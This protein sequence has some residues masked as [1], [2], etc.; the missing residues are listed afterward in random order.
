M[1]LLQQILSV[2][3]APILAGTL[4]GCEAYSQCG[5]SG[6]PGD[7]TITANVEAQF[8]RYPPLTANSV[9]I[10]TLNKVVYLTG[11][12]DTDVERLLAVSVASDVAD[13]SRVVDSISVENVSR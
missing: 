8:A 6:C 9:R 3:L 5:F 4:C 2:A 1:K 12:V 11:Q 13:V 10:Q 7:A